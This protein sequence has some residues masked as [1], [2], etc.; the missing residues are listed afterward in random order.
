[1]ATAMIMAKNTQPP[2]RLIDA[3]ATIAHGGATS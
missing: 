1:M 3:F 2:R